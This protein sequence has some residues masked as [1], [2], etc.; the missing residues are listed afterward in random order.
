MT[1]DDWFWEGNVQDR[2]ASHLESEGWEVLMKSDPKIRSQGYDL[3]LMKGDRRLAIEVKGYPST[4]YRDPAKRGK[5][6]PT[7][8]QTQAR[9]WFSH[10]LL[11]ALSCYGTTEFEV[12]DA[13][14][15]F[16][17]YQNLQEKERRAFEELGIG[18]Y[19]I[20]EDGTVY[21]AI[22]H[23]RGDGSARIA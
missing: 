14:P 12:A 20:R 13:F 10:A 23:L 4:Q 17:T 1:F 8:P 18:V 19:F 9:H 5:T 15:E 16:G 6:K 7:Q 21:S 22:K 2:L 3:L 11:S